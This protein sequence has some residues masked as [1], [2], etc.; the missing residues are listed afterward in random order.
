VL[1]QKRRE[2]EADGM[3]HVF[4]EIEEQRKV[5]NE[6]AHRGIMAGRAKA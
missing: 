1:V 4:R 2:S 5:S 6:V 3:N